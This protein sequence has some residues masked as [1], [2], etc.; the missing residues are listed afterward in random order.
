MCGRGPI[1][2]AGH[3]ECLR[4]LVRHLGAVRELQTNPTRLDTDLNSPAGRTK[5]MV[6]QYPH[7]F[8]VAPSYPDAI[9]LRRRFDTP[10]PHPPLT[11]GPASASR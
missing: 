2:R 10:P 5:R 11:E 4:R 6:T 8:G 3:V 1:L 7:F 9:S